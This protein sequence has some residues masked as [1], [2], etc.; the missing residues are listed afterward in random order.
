MR[1][2]IGKLCPV[3][4]SSCQCVGNHCVFTGEASSLPQS[5]VPLSDNS[6]YGQV[7]IVQQTLSTAQ[8]ENITK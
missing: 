5:E 2:L 1:I 8:Y 7:T 4:L 3:S 6:A